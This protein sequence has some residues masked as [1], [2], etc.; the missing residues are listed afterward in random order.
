MR[1]NKKWSAIG[2]CILLIV[3]LS[4]A[5][6]TMVI[7]TDTSWG[8]VR[9]SQ[10]NLTTGDGDVI[11]AMLYRP[12]S[13]TPEAKAPGVIM[14][15]GGND[16]LEHTG[17]YALELA[18]RGYVVVNFDYQGSHDSD[19]ATG[20]AENGFAGGETILAAM[21]RFNF[22]D[23]SKIAVFGHSMGGGYASRFAAAHDD[24]IALLVALGTMPS[25]F[26]TTPAFDYVLII[27]DSDE[28]VLNKTNN[29][30]LDYLKTPDIK[31]AFYNDFTSDPASLA[32][33][34]AA[35]DYT[36]VAAD[37]VTYHRVTYVPK[38]IHAYYNVTNEAVRTVIYAFTSTMGVGQDKG[39]NSYADLGKISTVWQVKDF[40]WGLEYLAILAVMFLVVTQLVRAKF[41][42]SLVLE[43]AEPV[44]FPK[45]SAPWWVCLVLLVVL[46][47]LLY[48]PGVKD[49]ARKF[50]GIDVTGMWLIG[51]TANCYVTWQ[52]MVAAAMLAIFLVYHFTWGKKHGG[53]AKTYGLATSDSKKFD[54]A[55]L[56]KALLFGIIVVGCGYLLMALIG[57]YTQQGLHITTMQIS[58]LK[59]NRVLC[60][61][62]Y[63]FYLIPYFLCTSLAFKTLNIKYD[64]SAATI[65]KNVVI[66]TLISVI[67]LILFWAYFVTVLSTQHV[68]IEIFRE[69]LTYA[70]G[71]A[72]M[73]LCIGI[74]VGNALNTYVS[75][76]T[77]SCWAGLCTALL[78][79]V[80]TLCST[81]GMTRYF[82]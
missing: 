62:V 41:F 6:L 26:D 51:G 8:R 39:V 14:Y 2:I 1:Q 20:K 40:G 74:A 77:N 44:G 19:I 82:F 58:N 79:G 63:F 67:G 55:Y 37:G 7:G 68:I 72:M 70:Y 9:M 4:A 35:R 59:Y 56:P 47:A 38:S 31:R 48:Y 16:M 54:P 23:Q 27:G 75:S 33:V 17:T 42:K 57:K 53:C 66:T 61:L 24:Q 52:W 50:L 21:Q 78:W 80:W 49:G 3:A 73:P 64:G 71:I 43:P 45:Y 60:W 76:K 5:A 15:H 32:P 12:N 22:V 69:N 10:L 11:H 25:K 29:V 36:A 46:P 18:R 81:G 34:E 65:A 28:S 30:C 13:A